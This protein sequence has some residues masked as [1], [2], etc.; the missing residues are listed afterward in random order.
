MTNDLSIL[1]IA[2]SEKIESFIR[3][4]Q[5][6][7]KI[8]LVIHPPGFG[9]TYTASQKLFSIP[10]ILTVWL[11]PTHKQIEESVLNHLENYVLHL[12]G[13]DRKCLHKEKLREAN[14]YNI[15]YEKVICG[16]CNDNKQCPYHQQFKELR[17][18]PVSWVGVHHHLRNKFIQDF[19]NE[20]D[21][22]PRGLVIDEHF[23]NSLVNEVKLNKKDLKDLIIIS[24]KLK[25]KLREKSD[26]KNLSF[27]HLIII[28]HTFIK[29]LSKTRKEG[30]NGLNFVDTFFEILPIGKA[31]YSIKEIQVNLTGKV[32]YEFKKMY[33]EEIIKRYENGMPVKNILYEVLEITNQCIDIYNNRPE[34][35]INLPFYSIEE[36]NDKGE[37]VKNICYTEVEKNLPKVPIII[38]DATGDK[39]FYETLFNREVEL[40]ESDIK[41]ER[42]IIQ[43]TDG[44]YW[45]ESFKNKSTRERIFK[46]VSSVIK[47]HLNDGETRVNIITYKKLIKSLS[48]FLLDSGIKK[49]SF[50]VYN[51]GGIK[52]LNVMKDNNILILIGVNEPNFNTYSKQVA[53]WYQG[54]KPIN[55]EKIVEYKNS[56]FYNRNHRYKDK[57]Y[58]SHVKM[59]REHEIEQA[60]ERLRF[61]ESNSKKKAYLFSALPIEFPTQK[62]SVWELLVSVNPE[63]QIKGEI[64]SLQHDPIYVYLK[65]FREGDTKTLI[66][67]KIRNVVPFKSNPMNFDIISKLVFERGYVIQGEEELWITKKGKNYIEFIENEIQE[68]QNKLKVRSI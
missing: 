38:M 25:W 4:N 14:K 67:E 2:F 66:Y 63:E 22:L 29:L 50:C 1:R 5:N 7:K 33:N 53:V 60:I 18:N 16:Q 6:G 46:T 27:F 40:Y 62:T 12:E 65:H 44:M 48:K 35:D 59:V 57:R 19:F 8:L 31:E 49:D 15:S 10:D 43:T 61:I 3:E 64:K 30:F 56:P 24:R 58:F 13:I 34:K 28:I 17:N 55:N 45:Q 20:N 9:K 26:F 37:L 47:Y 41:I 32:M 23:T 39:E 36:S 21:Y 51:Y 52:G 11:A 68:L 42:N 54:E